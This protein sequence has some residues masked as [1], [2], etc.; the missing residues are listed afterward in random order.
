MASVISIDIQV[1]RKLHIPDTKFVIECSGAVFD[2][3]GSRG[4]EDT[5]KQS[6]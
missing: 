1:Y 2:S 3:V 6:N 5:G 4:T